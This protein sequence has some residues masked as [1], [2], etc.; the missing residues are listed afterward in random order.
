MIFA[1]VM[2][3]AKLQTKY[4]CTCYSG[5]LL[6]HINRKNVYWFCRSCRQEMPNLSLAIADKKKLGILV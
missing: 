5:T 1:N 4:V 2:K 6:R 3:A